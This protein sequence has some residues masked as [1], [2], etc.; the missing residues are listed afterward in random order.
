MHDRPQRRQ[1]L[2]DGGH[3][4][5][6][7]DE[8]LAVAVAGDRQQN[9][10]LELAQ[11][12]DHAPRTELGRA[13]C[14]DGAEARRREE[15]DERLGDVREIGD[16]AVAGS[17]AESLQARARSRDLLTQV[18]E[19]QLDRPPRLRSGDDRHGVGV[20]VAAEHVLRE[21][22]PRAREPLGPRHL[23]RPEH[24]LVRR[25]RANLEVVPERAPEAFEVADRPAVKL[26]VAGEVE[27][28][29]VLQPL[30]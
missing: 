13:R 25:V 21:V 11:P 20:L 10:R 7:I 1:E 29:L 3:L 17:D 9:G 22:E 2:P 28:A 4:F 15:G 18:A 16:D 19:R 27:P 23:P 24:P 30:R 6:A 26:V 8:L 12:A 5:A 14:P